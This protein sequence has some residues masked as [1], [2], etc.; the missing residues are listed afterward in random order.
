MKGLFRINSIVCV[1]IMLAIAISCIGIAS[2][3]ENTGQGKPK[4]MDIYVGDIP[5]SA[6]LGGAVKVGDF[7]VIVDDN[8]PG[9]ADPG[10][11]TDL[12]KA[13]NPNP[14]PTP[15]MTPTPTATAAIPVDLGGKGAT[16]CVTDA[17]T[18]VIVDFAFASAD[19]KNTFSLSSPNITPLGWSQGSGTS[20]QGDPFGTIWNLGKF[21]VGTKLIFKDIAYSGSTYIGTWVTGP[22]KNN[23]DNFLHASITLKNST[24]TYHKYLVSFEDAK[25]GGDKDYNDVEFYVSGDVSTGCSSAEEEVVEGGGGAVTPV[26]T[27]KICRCQENRDTCIAQFA[28]VNTAGTMNIPVKTMGGPSNPPWN[29]FT[30]SGWTSPT[31][32]YHCQPSWFYTNASNSPFWTS[33]FWNNIDWKLA[34]THSNQASC[35]KYDSRNYNPN[36]R[37]YDLNRIPLCEDLHVTCTQCA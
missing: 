7:N 5:Y 11:F 18:D 19:Y 9:R 36:S 8:N 15:T 24:G 6:S 29:E 28:Y 35:T 12:G 32:E 20:R 10:W 17:T 26:Y 3:V 33:P 13:T 22:A 34:N 2:A 27:G 30:G 1:L 14:T 31:K 4:G 25:N 16:L 23:T 37:F 21:P